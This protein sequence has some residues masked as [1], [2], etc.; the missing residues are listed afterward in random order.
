MIEL[1][2]YY[3]LPNVA[4]FGSIVLLSKLIE[5]LFWETFIEQSADKRVQ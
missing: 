4:L 5:K 1:F 2:T 3:I